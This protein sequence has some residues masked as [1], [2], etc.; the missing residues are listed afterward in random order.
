LILGF[1]IVQANLKVEVS[2]KEGLATKIVVE[3]F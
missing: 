1:V 3:K 2:A